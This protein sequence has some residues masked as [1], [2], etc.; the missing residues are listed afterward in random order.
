MV[1]ILS[2]YSNG[3]SE[4]LSVLSEKLNES[5]HGM[6]I[7]FQVSWNDGRREGLELYIEFEYKGLR[8]FTS[9]SANEYPAAKILSDWKDMKQGID[10]ELGI[11]P[12][13]KWI[14]V[15]KLEFVNFAPIVSAGVERILQKCH[16]ELFTSMGIP[17][18][19]LK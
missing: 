19:L 12:E 9:F 16:D 11:E 7:L 4:Q 6:P 2:N 1:K 18:N 15:D 5:Y 8:G 3:N 17:S 13:I 14:T 10:M